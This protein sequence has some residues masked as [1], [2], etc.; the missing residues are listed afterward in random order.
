MLYGIRRIS[1]QR[2]TFATEIGGGGGENIQPTAFPMIFMATS[3]GRSARRLPSGEHELHQGLD[4]RRIIVPFP[5]Q[6]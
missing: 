6:G 5:D 1:H 2:M 3:I 4:G